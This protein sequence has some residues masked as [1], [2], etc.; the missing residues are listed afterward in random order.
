MA[1]EFETDA[2]AEGREEA[3]DHREHHRGRTIAKWAGIVLAAI[4]VLIGLLLI[5]LN[6][7]PGKRFIASQIEGLG[8]ENGM[9]IG[10][11][12]IDGSIYGEMIL[13]DLAISDPKG[14]F[15]SS[16]EVRVD[17]RPFAFIGNH[18][19]VRSLTSPLITLRRLPE[20]KETPPSNEPLLPDLDI[21]IGTLK[22]DRFVAEAPVSGEQRVA[23]LAGSAHIADGRAQVKFN[24]RTL[25]A[26][27]AAGGDRVNLTLDAVPERNR[28]DLD[29][30]LSAPAGGVIAALARI[31]QPLLVQAKGKGDWA[32]WNGQ[33]SA[34]LGGEELA[35]LQ[36]EARNGTFGLRGPTRV[37]RLF[38][39]P[40]ASLL[41]PVLDVN[42]AAAL[43]DRRA[44]LSGGLSSDAFQ[45]DAAG[46]VDLANNRFDDLQLAF[47]LLK[48]S[49]LAEN[50]SGSAIR[51][52]LGLDGEFAT[53]TVDYKI[54]A[55]ALTMNDLGLRD[56]HAEGIAKV[57]AEH[58]MIPVEARV[59]RIVGLD[60]VAGGTL[61]NVRLAGDLAID[62]TRILSDNM[63]IRSDRIDAKVIL[64]ADT[65]TGLYTGAVDGRIDNYR[66][67]S[68]GMLDI[69]TDMDLKTAPGGGF[70]VDGRVAARSTQLFNDGI[71]NFLGG[72]AAA[73]ADI[74]YG[75]DGTVRFS[76][77]QL[78]APAARIVG[79]SGSYSPDGRITLNADGTTRAY[80]KVGVRVAGTISD[81][82]AT[83]TAERPGFGVGLANLEAKVTGA[84]NGY[85]L[86]AD[87]DTDYG[88]LQADVVLGMGQQLTLDINRADFAGI[89]F[90]GGLRQTAAGPFA[91]RL[92]ANGRGLAGVVRLDA[93]GNYQEALV[94]LRARDTVLPGPANLSIGSAI[95]DARVVLYDQPYVVAKVD[96]A[97]TTFGALN[98]N[99]AK[100]TID[101]RNGTGKAQ[102]LAEG[103]SGVPFRVAANAELQPKLWRA[104]LKGRVRG[105]D[106]RTTT[107]ARIVPG[108]GS[109]ELLPTRID[110][111]QGSLRLAGKYGEGME[112]QSRLDSLDLSLVNAFVP[113]L[114]VD[115]TAT[116]S[117]DF[118][119]ADA[120]AFPRA[121][122]RLTINDFS[123]TT[124]AS[125]SQPIDINLVG[126]LLPGGGEARAVMRQRG[127]VIGRMVASLQPLPPGTGS[128]SERLLSAPLGGGI[129]YNG[130]ADTLFSFAGQ[131]DQRL[132]GPIAV[133]ADFSGRVQQPQL[134]G[135][136]RAN[137]LTYENQ[138]YGTRLSNMAVAGSFSGD[139]LQLD[140]LTATAGDGTV[141]ASGFVS[142]ASDSGYPMDLRVTLDEA[143]LARSDALAAEAT[144]QLRLTKA[145]GQ[146]ALL[147]GQIRLPE[148]RYQ[149]IRQGAAEVPE[150]TGVRFKPPKGPQRITGDEP[151][152]PSPGVLGLIRLD[153][154]LTA[155][156]KLYVSGMGLESEWGADLR[157]AG[158]SADPRITGD[159]ELIRGTLGFAGRS[160]ELSE[161]RVNFTGG[162]EI[163][164]TINMVAT[165][166]IEDV[167]VNVNVTGR[168]MDP[169]IAFSSVPGLPQDEVLSRILFGSSI[170][171]LSTIQAV[172]L[173]A[174][175]NS[176]RGSGGGLNP[177]GKLRSA[178][179]VDRLRILGSDKTTG[180]GT[181]LAAGQY[182]T[183]DIYVEFITDARGFTATQL[184]IS[185]TPALSILSQAG[186]S[187]ST[188][189]N[190]R[191]KKDY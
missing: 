187:G 11:G 35:R 52:A 85:R 47:R 78:T 151:V 55:G 178:S 160:F 185:L 152:E 67:E 130:P 23:T 167:T 98:L 58:I 7:A 37:A 21:D 129:R 91:G 170:G 172:Q 106:F 115:G 53:P 18:V 76:N 147:S 164:P 140:K 77:L 156:E 112:V 22:V 20:F 153:V 162:S 86:V 24:G 84:P 95:V 28:L 168:A 143:Q 45:L 183:D 80:G 6:T 161:G 69:R 155:P 79:G 50:L 173:A 31:D 94:N 2:A 111:G 148:A 150:L 180:R 68:V 71:R 66:L 57:D 121:D 163:N 176:L 41:G 10:V 43:Q 191:Y 169:Q 102:L 9:S 110:F 83:I 108:E 103:V 177:L 165:D 93:E 99:A 63:R 96:L 39:G 145:A 19:D 65:S 114:G 15:V 25:A 124:A 117:V 141:Q 54:D 133:A 105:I 60:T 119:Q 34:D 184:E 146:T 134:R 122:A 131:A 113:G 49:A 174:S 13:H 123:R 40:T 175:L 82:R 44:D 144:G 17:W 127:S 89:A 14:V 3:L 64:L 4:V 90:S 171:N 30:D 97:R 16:P 101:Y 5:G 126:K 38:Q 36:L 128:W 1:E 166:D 26:A 188:N 132:S 100:A 75:P 181:A 157:L 189:V 81:P 104:A 120:S 87:A 74:R 59:G 135:I 48:P 116:G 70:V 62:G 12:R 139:R 125:V 186:G 138:T 149:I 107:P 32:A 179:G 73:A 190:L 136:I 137:A 56:L 88:P 42:L 51:A 142:L 109:Y 33:L 46:V 92:D 27:G 8:F 154:A 159:V 72:N 158:T 182:L 29:L 61:A 118:S